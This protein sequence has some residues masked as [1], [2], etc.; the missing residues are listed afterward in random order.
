MLAVSYF[1]KFKD[2]LVQKIDYLE[3]HEIIME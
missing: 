1:E 3:L 2:N